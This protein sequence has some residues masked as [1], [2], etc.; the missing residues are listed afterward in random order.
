MTGPR[1]ADPLAPLRRGAGHV[2]LYGHRGAR[3]IAPENTLPSIDHMLDAGLRGLEIDVCAT[4]DGVPV[5]THDFHLAPDRTRGPD[6]D[7]VEPPGP[8][9]R[10]L[11]LDQ[12]ARYDVGKLREGSAY[13]RRFPE[14]VAMPGLR[15]PTL[16]A[17]YARLAEFDEPVWVMLE[18]KSDPATPGHAPPLPEYVASVIEVVRW[19]EL[20]RTTMLHAFDWGVLA[21][22]AR[23]APDMARSYLSL[24]A[25]GM[26]NGATLY[27]GSPWLNGAL[28]DAADVPSAIAALGGKA[29][30]PYLLDVTERDV[31]AAHR[32]G[33]VVNTWTVNAPG[34]I[35]RMVDL[36]VDGICTDYAERAMN[37]LRDMGLAATDRSAAPARM[38]E[39]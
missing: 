7:W 24:R 6:G 28:E 9:V 29:W 23:Q 15:V 25:G 17:V 31:E 19:H 21:E 27:D 32:L 38:R 5:V 26:A 4:S 35:R 1:D 11:S 20:A 16:D 2:W 3:G 22:C 34:D 14:Q 30:A 8:R 13:A 39:G 18:I 33:L 10:D 37:V 12:L 36:G